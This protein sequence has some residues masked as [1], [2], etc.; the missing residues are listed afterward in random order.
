M[1]TRARHTP[2][3]WIDRQL[4]GDLLTGLGDDAE[5]FEPQPQEVLEAL[6]REP[7]WTPVET[8][9]MPSSLDA[10]RPVRRQQVSEVSPGV[11][12]RLEAQLAQIRDHASRSGALAHAPAPSP[13]DDA[14]A[15]APVDEAPAPAP[16][17]EAP[18]PDAAPEPVPTPEETAAAQQVAAPTDQ[19]PS[20]PEVT[21]ETSVWT[22][23]QTRESESAGIV[24][25]STTSALELAA[26]ES[27][28][29]DP[30]QAEEV[31]G[32]EAIE[33]KDANRAAAPEQPV[34]TAS[35]PD[36]PPRQTVDQDDA[37]HW[38]AP[39]SPN[40][41][42]SPANA[43]LWERFAALGRWVSKEFDLGRYFITDEL[44]Q[45]IETQGIDREFIAGGGALS[46]L[47]SRARQA[48]GG[49]ELG[50]HLQVHDQAEAN[51]LC[52][53]NCPTRDYPIAMGLLCPDRIPINGMELIGQ[54]LKDTVAC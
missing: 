46:E 49:S 27:L 28:P 43:P 7:S 6:P 26:L 40:P 5:A 35:I 38:V 8:P 12:S 39:E 21:T 9:L 34:V 51:Y 14:P 52:V 44:G 17:D 11:Q 42:S 48:T 23:F 18:A 47:M 20:Q 53:V 15:P 30:A 29:D 50:I 45:T 16:V 13:N 3:L 24:A 19:V 33:S 41:F 22:N 25:G 54:A 10:D 32:E 36:H 4:L 31:S 2:R 1:E 37:E